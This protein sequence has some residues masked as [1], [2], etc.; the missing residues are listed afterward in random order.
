M[1]FRGGDAAGSTAS[2]NETTRRLGTSSLTNRVLMN[3]P[4]LRPST[5]C[6]L[7]ISLLHAVPWDGLGQFL[8]H[9]ALH[10]R[11][12]AKHKQ[13]L[14]SREF[15]AAI[16]GGCKAFSTSFSSLMRINVGKTF[17][18]NVIDDGQWMMYHG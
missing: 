6:S 18:V 13:D 16:F 4:A 5:L 11:S 7:A 1:S 12:I 15:G 8:L 2:L 10:F 9:T 14:C 17:S 3:P